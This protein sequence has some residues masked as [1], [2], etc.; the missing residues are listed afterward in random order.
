MKNVPLI[1]MVVVG[2]A[3]LLGGCAGVNNPLTDNESLLNDQ[4]IEELEKAIDQ[5]PLATGTP[6]ATVTQTGSKLPTVAPS[7]AR[8]KPTLGATDYGSLE[9]DAGGM[10]L[11]SETIE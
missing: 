5:D 7:A 4:A 6:A 11:D 10:S 9:K 8:P 2:S 1:F 3:L